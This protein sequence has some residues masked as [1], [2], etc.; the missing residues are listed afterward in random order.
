MKNYKK[1]KGFTLIEIVVS[2]AII[3]I[4]VVS[5]L[6]IISSSFIKVLNLGKNTENIVESHSN[7]Q[8][9]I[10]NYNYKKD[11]VKDYETKITYTNASKSTTLD[12]VYVQSAIEG[13]E[14]IGV[15]YLFGY[16]RL[17]AYDYRYRAVN[18]AYIDVNKN[19]I[20]DPELDI[21]VPRTKEEYDRV[22]ESPA[23]IPQLGGNLN[24]KN[25]P[26]YNTYLEDPKVEV[27]YNFYAGDLIIPGNLDD[28]FID[29][30]HNIKIFCWGNIILSENVKLASKGEIKLISR[31]NILVNRGNIT[32]G[33]ISLHAAENGK[34]APKEGTTL[35]VNNTI[36]GYIYLRS[37]SFISDNKIFLQARKKVQINGTKEYGSGFVAKNEI[38]IHLTGASELD[39][40]GEIVFPT[41]MHSQT[42]ISIDRIDDE[43]IYSEFKTTGD[44]TSL[45]TTSPNYIPPNS[46]RE[47]QENLDIELVGPITFSGVVNKK[48]FP[49]GRV[50]VSRYELD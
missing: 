42:R 28:P 22:K 6:P 36:N 46:F 47:I 44:A 27:R 49:E 35:D 14:N 5:F 4:L 45:S 41:N 17:K 20:F 32:A 9:A 31:K 33:N 40:D 50:F 18:F 16:S 43:N 8:L 38:A 11:T 23:G 29:V 7:I 48:V 19:R 37:S 13:E 15:P 12:N 1:F 26:C 24:A 21:Y 3:G 25:T 30:D 2:L 34:I 10:T 39:E